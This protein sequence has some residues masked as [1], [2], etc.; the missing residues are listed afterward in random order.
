MDYYNALRKELDG[1]GYDKEWCVRCAIWCA[2]KVL[3]IW[4]TKFPRKEQP[5]KAVQVAQNWL[6]KPNGVSDSLAWQ[7]A[8]VAYDAR[9]GGKITNHACSACA[10]S[11]ATASHHI[12]EY[13]LNNLAY[14]VR[15]AA[16][17]LN[18][19]RTCIDLFEE[20]K[21]SLDLNTV[22]LQELNARL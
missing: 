6:D 2:K 10:A 4:E 11:A 8:S 13:I 9:S 5:R 3:P 18:D 7:A 17:A 22:S 14:V 15:E 16:D 1:K 20:Y 19:G 12:D 21:K